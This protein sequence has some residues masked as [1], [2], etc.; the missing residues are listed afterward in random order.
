MLPEPLHAAVVHFPIV[1]ATLLPISILAAWWTIRR[2]SRPR[3]AWAVPLAVAVALVAS[4]WVAIRTGE[5]EEERVE[6]IVGEE[7]LHEHEEAAERLLVLAGIVAAV[8]AAGLVAGTVGT[9]ARVVAAV[10]SALVLAAGVQVGALGGELVYLHG[11]AGAYTGAVGTGG[12]EP[13]ERGDRHGDEG[14]GRAAEPGGEGGFAQATGTPGATT[15]IALPGL[16]AIMRGLE[17]EVARLDRG[18]WKADADT[19]AAAVADHPHV[20]PR[21]AERIAGVL[22][23]DMARFAGM[24][25]RVHDVAVRLREDA[26]AG[27]MEAVLAGQ[28]ELRRGCVACHTAFREPLRSRLR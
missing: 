17:A 10:G 2:G 14:E 5:A 27:D 8:A 13:E 25:T 4:S 1:L 26:L 11:A 6:A 21:E 28:G 16:F 9:A 22:G 18:V 12:S 23:A 24:D 19:V 20:P 3:S 15:R 7:L